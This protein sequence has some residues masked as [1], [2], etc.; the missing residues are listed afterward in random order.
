MK[1]IIALL[2]II[3][4]I[5]SIN[6]KAN[7]AGPLLV[8]TTGQIV[9]YG[10]R[11]LKYRFD[12]GPMGKFSNSETVAIIEELFSRWES[13]STAKV[14]FEKDSTPFLTEDVT[15]N[16]Y[17]IIESPTPVGFTPVIFDADGTI[18][19]A[20]FGGGA[21]NQVLGFAGPAFTQFDQTTG[22]LEFL[23][24]VALFNGRFINGISSS[25][26]RESTIEVFKAT[27]LHEF[28]HAV[29]LDHSQINIEAIIR[30]T[31]QNIRDAVPLMFPVAVNN[32]F[33]ILRDDKSAISLVYPNQTELAK[34]G[35]IN[36]RI[37]RADGT[38]SVL[39]A[40]VIARNIDNPLLEAVSCVSGYMAGTDGSFLLFALPPGKY[41]VEVEPINSKFTGGSSVGHYSDEA[42]GASFQNPVP[43]GYYQGAT[44]PITTD[45]TKA[46]VIDVAAGQKI[47]GI[48]IVA[49][50][51]T[52][53]TSTSSTS[54]T[55]TSSTSSTSGTITTSSSSTST[56]SGVYISNGTTPVCNS[57]V[58]GL[59]A[60]IC[61]SGTAFC[62]SGK[63][64][65]ECRNFL[66]VCQGVCVSTNGASMDPDADACGSLSGGGITTSTS[67]SSTSSTSGVLI[68]NGTVPI[69]SN[70]SGAP[71]S[72]RSGTPTCASGKGTIDCKSFNGSCQA[73][74]LSPYSVDPDA[75][76]CAGSSSSTSGGS[77]T[78]STSGSTG[79][80]TP[81]TTVV[82]TN[83]PFCENNSIKCQTGTPACPSDGVPVCGSIFGFSG[84]LGGPGCVNPAMTAFDYNL[85]FC[86]SLLSKILPVET[87]TPVQIK[88]ESK[89][90]C[91][92]EKTRFKPCRF[93]LTSCK[94]ECPFEVK[95]EKH[96]PRCNK[97]DKP[98]CS[99]DFKAVCNKEE[100][101]PEC[102]SGKLFCR[103]SS[104]ATIDL[105]DRVRCKKKPD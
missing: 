51:A 83:I 67:S 96:T 89:E 70:C 81:G 102:N 52:S 2:L 104:S 80:I 9:S 22:R 93:D 44:L 91:P 4:Q 84:S 48:N 74:C 66:G 1:K 87:N 63:G 53:S 88:C 98:I 8:T 43:N 61:A 85:A 10:S 57:C 103:N 97:K 37:L 82:S 75:D 12:L 13:V 36:G 64:H 42:T 78:S 20:V 68:S 62:P 105:I 47:S 16:N 18:V 60:P 5:V 54:T 76:F 49:A 72:C 90:Q 19:D 31:A 73:V 25:V 26:D 86:R 30:G 32:L 3:L 29:G 92:K 24:S 38:T 94:C 15:R 28:G 46:L 34:F 6:L 39:G 7:A 40:N 50:L 27:A 45:I 21:G 100:N 99:G 59:E 69:C 56:T 55:T 41:R 58:S 23:E 35:E 71:P 77:T 33:D 17:S 95:K 79:V 11:P 65:L 101:D 14:K